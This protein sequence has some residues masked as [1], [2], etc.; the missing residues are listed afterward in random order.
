MNPE[1]KSNKADHEGHKYIM[2]QE[3][4]ILTG[5]IWKQI[6]IFFFPILIGTFFQ[7][8]YNTVDAIV[9]GRFAGKIALSSVGGSSSIIINLVVGFFTGLSAGCTVMISQFY[10][11]KKTEELQKGLHT[12]YAFGIIGGIFFGI[13]GVIFSPRLLAIMNTPEELMEQSTLYI[14]VYFAGLIFVFLYNLGSAILR[15]IGDSKR[16]LYFLIICSAVNI[17]LDLLFVLV[18]QMGVLGVALATLISQAISVILITECLMHRTSGLQL[19]LK[20]IRIHPQMIKAM[21]KIGFPSGIQS[22]TY[23]VSNMFIQSA[24]N[25]FGVNT[26]AAWTAYGKLDVLFWMINGSFGIAATTFVGQNLGAG[27]YDRMKK[28][29]RTVL[30]MAIGSAIAMSIFMCSAGRYLLFLFT[31]DAEVLSIGAHMILLIAPTYALFSFI[32]IFSASLRA[33]G[34]TLIPTIINITGICVLR[35]IWIFTLSPLHKLDA[36]LLC[37]PVSWLICAVAITI[38]YIHCRKRL[39]NYS[40]KQEV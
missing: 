20:E 23:S 35:A 15:A 29:T 40:V 5:T 25:L 39:P 18:F 33:Q 3:N 6:L 17:V 14:R 1:E 38:Y 4:K 34:N 37:Y 27:N 10:G 9:V 11:A 21:L 31:T 19:R 12:T 13:L 30:F 36:I 8:L 28:G 16:P 26:M 32:E 24:I 22:S 2:E 7:Q